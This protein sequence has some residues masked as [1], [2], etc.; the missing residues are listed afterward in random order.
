MEAGITHPT[1]SSFNSPV[2]PVRK[3]NGT[4][5]MTVDYWELN[6]MTLLLFAAFPSVMDLM[7]HLSLAMGR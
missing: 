7:D 5:C 4:W 1:H 2:W 6:K 3:L